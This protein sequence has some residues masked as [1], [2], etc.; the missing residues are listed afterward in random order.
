MS[1]ISDA[2]VIERKPEA[3]QLNLV[4]RVGEKPPAIGRSIPGHASVRLCRSCRRETLG[5]VRVVGKL[6]DRWPTVAKLA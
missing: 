5:T 6:S 1:A 4:E 2:L 3:I